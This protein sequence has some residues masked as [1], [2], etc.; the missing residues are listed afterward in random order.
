MIMD[1]CK[2]DE[3]QTLVKHAVYLFFIR[4]DFFAIRRMFAPGIRWIT[5]GGKDIG[6]QIEEA[7]DS[8]LKETL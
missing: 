6:N 8:L 1:G 5:T 7:Y 3:A 2:Q 4:Q